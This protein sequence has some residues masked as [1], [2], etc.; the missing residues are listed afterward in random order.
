VW[1]VPLTV[2]PPLI[3]PA[4]LLAYRLQPRK[5]NIMNRTIASDVQ[6]NAQRIATARFALNAAMEA[7]GED[8]PV[9][10]EAVIDLLADLRH[11]CS[12]RHI[13]FALC[14]RIAQT[15]FDVEF[16]GQR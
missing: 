8:F 4:F 1:A 7:R 12:A 3:R 16:G 13:D 2:I 6:P 11:F 10:N 14:D 9:S 15:S 5:E